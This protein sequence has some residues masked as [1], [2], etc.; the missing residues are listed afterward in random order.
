M[1]L[2]QRT[3]KQQLESL[4]KQLVE[5]QWHRFTCSN[6]HCNMLCPVG[7]CHL[8]RQE[9]LLRL[10]SITFIDLP[11]TSALACN[12][13]AV[14]FTQRSSLIF[15]HISY[16]GTESYYEN[17][18]CMDWLHS[19]TTR[20][21]ITHKQLDWDIALTDISHVVFLLTISISQPGVQL[22]LAI[23]TTC[24]SPEQQSLPVFGLR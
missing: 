13:S 9:S 15:L 14:S 7:M 11:Q 12:W 17:A 20:M 8:T 6:S 22:S 19:H 4:C 3:V 16:T 18:K 23:Y 21:V 1:L 24:S 10:G 5:Q 2:Y